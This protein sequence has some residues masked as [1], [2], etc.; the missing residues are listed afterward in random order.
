M[1]EW[2]P[3]VG[4]ELP[5]PDDRAAAWCD[6]EPAFHRWWRWTMQRERPMSLANSHRLCIRYAQAVLP[7]PTQGHD[8]PHRR[9]P[10]LRAHA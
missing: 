3:A 4:D 8:P 2:P 6:G 9:Q 5:D 7:P 1:R 10:P